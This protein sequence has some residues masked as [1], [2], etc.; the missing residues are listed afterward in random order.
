MTTTDRTLLARLADL[1]PARHE[2]PTPPEEAEATLQSVRA[3]DRTEQPHAKGH[4]GRRKILVGAAAAVALAVVGSVTLPSLLGESVIPP[5]AAIPMLDYSQPDGTDA[6]ADLNHL[7][8]QLRGP[9]GA[10]EA[11]RYHFEHRR[12]VGYS[13]HEVEV[14]EGYWEVDRLELSEVDSYYW[15]DTTDFSGGSRDVGDG[16]GPTFTIPAGEAAGQGDVPDTPQALYDLIMLNNDQHQRFP[17]HY[18]IDAYNHQANRLGHDDRATF[19]GAIALADDVTLYGQ[20]TD[21]NGRDGVSFGASRTEEDE[22]GE[23]IEIE[24]I[25]IIDPS[26]GKVLETDTIYP[27]DLPGAPD[28]VEEYELVVESRYTDTLPLCGKDTCPGASTTDG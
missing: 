16:A 7:A 3:H 28:V 8:D 27:N 10:D 19:L 9:S 25:T 22:E 17:G 21:R 20:V 4:V 1:D 5:A 23:T 12:Y 11:G 13:M 15:V 18:L 26:T 2:A 24:L 14:S 6:T